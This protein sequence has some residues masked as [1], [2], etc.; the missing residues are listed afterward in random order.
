MYNF[1]EFHGWLLGPKVSLL[2][3]LLLP[4]AGPE[5]FDEEDTQKLPVDLQFLPA[6]KE[7]EP[8]AD[9]RI[10]LLESLL[11]VS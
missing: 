7:R 5:D 1:L 9:L 4:L 6:E 11:Q 2:S 3:Y 10:I 8:D